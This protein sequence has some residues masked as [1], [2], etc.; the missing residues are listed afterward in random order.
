ML[1]NT[2]SHT[3]SPA[4]KSC[5]APN[6][7]STGVEEPRS[8]LLE[9]TGLPQLPFS[10]PSTASVASSLAW[11]G[12]PARS[13]HS[14]CFWLRELSGTGGQVSGLSC[15]LRHPPAS[16]PLSLLPLISLPCRDIFYL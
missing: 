10:P 5:P 2:V 14:L 6:V 13:L 3:G 9:E 8:Q 12:L 1:R 4:V 15:P 16:V 11:P 7:R